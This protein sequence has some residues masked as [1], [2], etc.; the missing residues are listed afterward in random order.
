MGW[1]SRHPPDT[2]PQSGA[3]RSCQPA[4]RSFSDRTCSRNRS[5]TA[6]ADNSVGLVESS[7]RVGDRAERKRDD[8]DIE[9][10]V[11]KGQMM[12]VGAVQVERRAG[13]TCLRSEFLEHVLVRFE[14]VHLACRG[15]VQRDIQTGSGPELE[16][17]PRQAVHQSA[18]LIAYAHPLGGSENGVVDPCEERIAHGD[19][20]LPKLGIRSSAST[21]DSPKPTI[22][23]RGTIGPS[24]SQGGDNG[25]RRHG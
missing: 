24:R 12:G 4:V 11:G 13:S 10:T 18:P 22:R 8:R 16:D 20:L 6:A 14:C 3:A 21:R 9:H 19:S 23:G 1:F 25:F 5:T 15:G 2:L 7:L 17:S